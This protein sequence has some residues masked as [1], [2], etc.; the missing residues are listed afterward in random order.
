MRSGTR[1]SVSQKANTFYWSSGSATVSDLIAA[2]IHS[3]GY[4]RTA[5]VAVY[6]SDSIE[7]GIAY[8]YS[9]NYWMTVT[10]SYGSGKVWVRRCSQGTVT[11]RSI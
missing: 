2:N 9:A 3:V 7:G 10:M 5:T 4:L 6:G 8:Y 1:H 11:A